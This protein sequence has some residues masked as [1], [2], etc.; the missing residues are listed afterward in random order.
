MKIVSLA[1]NITNTLV[2]LNCENDIIATTQHSNLNSKYSI[3]SWLSPNIAEIKRLDPDYVFT[4]DPLQS[5]IY[6]K[7]SNDN[8]NIY[9]FNL[10]QFSDVYTLINSL[11]SIIGKNEESERL[12]SE[13]NNRQTEVLNNVNNQNPVVYCEEWDNPT[14]V[15]G[16]WIPD[17]VEYAGGDYP[18]LSSGQRSREINKTEF[19]KYDPDIFISHICD[20]GLINDFRD[21]RD[22]WDTNLD[23]VYFV[24][25]NYTN[26]LSSRSIIGLEIFAEII[27]NKS[28]NK[29]EYY[30]IV[31][32]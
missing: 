5:K 9:H 23:K 21:I 22:N 11:G 32:Q 12:I 24:D 10:K 15:A 17:I 4:S 1:P 25:D 28:Y 8:M 18:F 31:K 27:Q 2:D 16:N 19:D 14:M 30:N 7:L 13:I 6:N 20:M 26:Q 29:D 3:G